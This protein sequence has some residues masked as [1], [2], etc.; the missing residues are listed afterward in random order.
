MAADDRSKRVS[1]IDRAQIRAKE[2]EL[3]SRLTVLYPL[4]PGP[5]THKTLHGQ[6]PGKQRKDGG[7][8][9]RGCK[10]HTGEV[11][12]EVGKEGRILAVDRRNKVLQGLE[13]YPPSSHPSNPQ[14]SPW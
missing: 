10:G 3:S 8:W 12:E 7:G 2:Q 1:P 6:S 4:R 13:M 14:M 11:H 5:V 9:G